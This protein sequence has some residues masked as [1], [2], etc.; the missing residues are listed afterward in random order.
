MPSGQFP[1][2]AQ[3]LLLDAYSNYQRGSKFG[4]ESDEFV[5]FLRALRPIL[6]A[7]L[8][9]RGLELAVERLLDKDRPTDPQSY[10]AHVNTDRGA[11]RFSHPA[12]TA[13]F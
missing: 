12:G 11:A 9:R 13:A 1:P 8:F 4:M 7:L 2:D 6:P 3:T 5:E 10:L